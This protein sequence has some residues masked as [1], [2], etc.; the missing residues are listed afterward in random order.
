MKSSSGEITSLPSVK[1]LKYQTNT[2]RRTSGFEAIGAPPRKNAM[3]ISPSNRYDNSDRSHNDA[4]SPPS[5]DCRELLAQLIEDPGASDRPKPFGRRRS[6]YTITARVRGR[7]R[8]PLVTITRKTARVLEALEK[9]G[10][11]GLTAL[12]FCGTHSF[13]IANYVFRLRHMYGLSI[14]MIRENHDDEDGGGWHGR[15]FLRSEVDILSRSRG[16]RHA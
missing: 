13:K 15:Y 1:H 2:K 3:P 16:V 11:A 10:D 9:A 12:E 4:G 14:E 6:S 8:N 5:N 7:M